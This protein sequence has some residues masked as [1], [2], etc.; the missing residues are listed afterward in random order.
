MTLPLLIAIRASMPVWTA[1]DDPDNLSMVPV[2]PDFKW[3]AVYGARHKVDGKWYFG[4]SEAFKKRFQTHK[5]QS[6]KKKGDK[7]F[8]DTYF[9]RATR[10]YGWD[11]FEWF[12]FWKWEYKGEL[13]EPEK[14]YLKDNFL[15]P[16]ETF[17]IKKYDTMDR[18]KGY[19]LKLSGKGGVFSADTKAKMSAARMGH[20]NTPT[21]PVIRWQ[22]HR[23]ISPEEQEVTLTSYPS[24]TAAAMETGF[25]GGS[26]TTACKN[27]GVASAGGF[28]W[29]YAAGFDLEFGK[30]IQVPRVGKI[31]KVKIVKRLIISVHPIPNGMA[32]EQWHDGVRPGAHALTQQSSMDN[33]KT[34]DQSSICHCLDGIRSQ[35]QGVY[36]R[37]VT[38]EKREHFNEYA[39]RVEAFVPELYMTK[40]Q[41]ACNKRKRNE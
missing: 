14:Q 12:I 31:P 22:I 2:D 36:F 8:V 29:S 4:E 26:I 9:Y 15:F 7:D 27:F 38:T 37:R 32:V 23:D 21:I 17:L 41:K 28:Y 34:F 25:N 6:H 16:A 20:T 3:A 24:G 18:S 30:V 35:H 13:T 40:K 1:P 19:N 33:P 39:T 11:A 10:K 5:R